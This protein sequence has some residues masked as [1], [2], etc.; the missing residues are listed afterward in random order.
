M[1]VQP[2]SL[3]NQFFAKSPFWVSRVTYVVHVT[4]PQLTWQLL[5]VLV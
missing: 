1:F 5:W 3:L 2:S 4:L